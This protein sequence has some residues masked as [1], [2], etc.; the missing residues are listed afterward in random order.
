MCTIFIASDH[1]GFKMKKEIIET[2]NFNKEE[3]TD[4][5]DVGCYSIDSCDYPEFAFRVG[6]KV[7]ETPNSFGVLLCGTGIGM[8]IAANKINGVRCALCNNYTSVNMSRRHNDANVI[9][10][11]SRNTTAEMLL[12]LILAFINTEFDGGRHQR[13]LDMIHAIE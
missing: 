10:L 6:K 4:I 8:S 2:L 11:G 1:A 7:T 13:R 12:P 9:A 3:V 5:V